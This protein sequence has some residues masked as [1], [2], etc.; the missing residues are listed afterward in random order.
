[1]VRRGVA[2]WGGYNRD[3]REARPY[4]PTS[5]WSVFQVVAWGLEARL[6]AQARGMDDQRV[7][8]CP[9]LL[10]EEDRVCRGHG[11]VKLSQK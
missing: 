3:Q 2:W 11:A 7:L 1:M 5:D 8:A 4:L 9:C 10:D 6:S